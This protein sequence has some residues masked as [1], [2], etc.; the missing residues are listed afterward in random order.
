MSKKAFRLESLSIDSG[1]GRK[2]P[3]KIILPRHNIHFFPKMSVYPIYTNIIFTRP[4]D[5][6]HATYFCLLQL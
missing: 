6:H 2:N 3:R 5:L 4:K 1:R